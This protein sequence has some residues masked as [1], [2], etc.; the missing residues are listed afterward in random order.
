MRKTT[1]AEMSRRLVLAAEVA[2]D[3]MAPNP[4]SIRDDA[5]IREAITLLADKGLD[6]VPVIDHAGRP[7]GVVSKGD[8][9]VHEREARSAPYVLAT[10]AGAEQT[11]TV[12]TRDIM[13]P[14]LFSVTPETPAAKVL[15]QLVMLRVNQLFVVDATG[16][17]IGVISS[18]D[19]LKHLLP[20]D[21]RNTESEVIK[22]VAREQP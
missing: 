13:T 20:D 8:I 12:H 10:A 4:I 18:L 1:Q 7:V 16:A 22:G 5:S 14:A 2:S 19:I 6:A 11:Q 15:E 17:L 3:V 21:E 9:L